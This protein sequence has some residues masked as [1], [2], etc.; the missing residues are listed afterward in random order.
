MTAGAPSNSKRVILPREDREAEIIAAA[1]RVLER[2]PQATLNEVADEAGVTR[3]LVSLYF[4]GGGTGPVVIN[5]VRN[6]MSLFR[7]LI[8]NMEMTGTLLSI[9]DEDELRE[10][11]AEGID[12]YI[13]GMVDVAPAWL[14]GNA[15][16][17]G[18]ADV[19]AEVEAV[20]A[21]VTAQVFDGDTRW[22]S[23]ELAHVSYE[24]V[25]TAC[26][27]LAYKYRT[28]EISRDLCARGMTEMFVSF[29]FHTLPALG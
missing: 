28:G 21:A 12:Q 3:Q 19:A 6:A 5:F 26:E 29:R 2:N 22:G 25:L 20:R 7:E 1:L 9:D 10:V 16:N 18:G 27:A 15:R 8:T 4:P 17:I 24:A 13:S 11:V 14:F 23:N